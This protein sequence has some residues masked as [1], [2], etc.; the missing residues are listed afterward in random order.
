MREI[1]TA[2]LL[3]SSVGAALSLVT[4]REN[5]R[6]FRAAVSTVII[7]LLITPL[8]DA[9]RSMDLSL[10]TGG[11]DGYEAEEFDLAIR[12]S[13]EGAI[14]ELIAGAVG[15]D[16]SLVSVSASDFSPTEMSCARLSVTLR[17]AAIYSDID[18]IKKTVREELGVDDVGIKFE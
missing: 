4:Y 1:F 11:A 3:L 17:G 6:A 10:G 16:S 15:C 9:V 8:V 2:A 5:D 14:A 13:Y 18:R 7:A 12:E